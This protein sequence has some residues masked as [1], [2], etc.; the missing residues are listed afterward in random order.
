MGHDASPPRPPAAFLTDLVAARDLSND[1]LERLQ[2]DWLDADAS[3][4]AVVALQEAANKLSIAEAIL[5]AP[6][7]PSDHVPA[8][9]LDA[10]DPSAA[11]ESMPWS[12]EAAAAIALAEFTIPY[13]TSRADAAGRWLRVLRHEGA[14]G[15]ALGDLGFP[16]AEL[17]DRAEPSA[18]PRDAAAL[19]AVRDKAV[20][21]TRHRGAESVTTTDLLFA[22]LAMYGGLAD[23]ALYAR[24]ITRP[25]LL[26]RVSRG[27]RAADTQLR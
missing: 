13:A 11:P 16:E 23:R 5:T 9:F 10:E 14:V 18:A 15:R 20:L 12:G 7:T 22:V 1:L 4:R 2:A 8:P 3:A 6:G 24:G 27:V 25:E 17:A 26:D 19:E 21:L